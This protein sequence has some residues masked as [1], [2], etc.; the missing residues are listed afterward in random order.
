MSKKTAPKFWM[1]WREGSHG[2]TYRH[3][4]KESAEQEAER[5]SKANPGETFFVLKAVGG[6]IAA[7]P[8]ISKIEMVKERP[9]FD[10][11]YDLPF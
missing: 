9:D 3:P 1:V 6:R 7:S 5:L 11:D 10:P 8:E 2:C 4:R